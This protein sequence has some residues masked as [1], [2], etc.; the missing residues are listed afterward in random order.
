MADNPNQSTGTPGSSDVVFRTTDL[1][2]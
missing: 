2:V 1:A